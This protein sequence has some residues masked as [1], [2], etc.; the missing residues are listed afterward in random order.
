MLIT[1]GKSLCAVRGENECHVYQ[2][3]S[4]CTLLSRFYQCQTVSVSPTEICQLPYVLSIPWFPLFPQFLSF[5]QLDFPP[6][7]PPA[8]SL[9][10]WERDCLS[11]WGSEG[12]RNP[13]S[14][15][16]PNGLPHHHFLSRIAGVQ[17]TEGIPT[18]KTTT[19]FGVTLKHKFKAQEEYL[20]QVPSL[21]SLPR[22]S[23]LHTIRHLPS[24][25]LA[26]ITG[27][28]THTWIVKSVNSALPS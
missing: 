1:L 13:K 4:Q 3:G 10:T 26:C 22:L 2:R 14:N 9:C 17:G 21:H 5:S 20:L 12:K 25:S 7:P 16:N 6:S 28:D 24:F 11:R 15:N 18:N 23:N 19:A 27:Q 8:L